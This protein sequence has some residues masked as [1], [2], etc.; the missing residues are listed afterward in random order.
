MRSLLLVV[1]GALPLLTSAW[2]EH[3]L[4]TRA[5]GNATSC[6][7]GDKVCGA[8][9]IPSDYTCCPDLE[10]GC[11]SKSVCQKGDNDVY[12]CCPVGDTCSGDGGAEF[13]DSES[14]TSTNTADASVASKTTT[15]TNAAQPQVVAN[16]LAVA[17]VA[18]GI[19][20]L[21]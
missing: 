4:L 20:A 16:G 3:T 13:L 12:G 14:S 11:S 6:E 17:I 1:V 21:L 8:F 15:A 2:S 19:A 9:C 5:T 7:S 18:A 10:G